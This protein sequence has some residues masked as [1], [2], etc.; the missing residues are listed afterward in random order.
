MQIGEV[1][2]RLTIAALTRE[3]RYSYAECRCSCGQ[4]KR[5]RVDHLKSKATRSCGCLHSELSSARTGK[6]QVANVRHGR[7]NTRVHSIWLGMLQRCRNP[8]SKYFAHYGGRGID[9]CDRWNSFHAFYEDMGD[10]PPKHTLER[11]DND[12]GY[13]PGNCEWA[14]RR[15]QQNNRR[16]NRRLTV[17]GVTNTIAEWSRLSG[18]HPNTITQRMDNGWPIDTIISP[19]KHLNISGLALGGRANGARL[20]AK[21]HCKRG[22]LFDATNTHRN[23]KQRICRTCRRDDAKAA[24]TRKR[25]QRS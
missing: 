11:V 6:M 21:T 17:N 3:G 20:L 4:T 12:K 5:V 25:A 22:H 19:D 23:G 13:D 8:N 7:S 14:T 9:V 10:P 2:G 18:V 24:R 16:T 1:F 15:T